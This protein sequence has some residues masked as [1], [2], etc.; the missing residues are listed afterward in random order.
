MLTRT[1][2]ARSPSALLDRL[3]SRLDALKDHA[4][5]FT[6]TAS[7]DNSPDDLTR[8]LDVLRRSRGPAGAARV[9]CL[10]TPLRDGVPLDTAWDCG[11]PGRE[12]ACASEGACGRRA[13][14][15][16]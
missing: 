10:S 11:D 4:L 1:F 12:M 16:C 8:L 15:R 14:R 9:G 6:L 3:A 7:V 13:R 5:L 2:L